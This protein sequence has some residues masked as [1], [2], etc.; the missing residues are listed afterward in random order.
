MRK[1]KILFIAT[2]WT[3]ASK[4][5]KD[6]LKPGYGVEELLSLYPETKELAEIDVYQL[7]NLDSTNVQPSDWTAIA[8]TIE[9]NYK[10]YDAFIIGHG[11]DTM[12][13]T[14][15]ALS[16]ALQDLEKPVILTGSVLAPEEPNSDAKQNLIDSILLSISE[17]YKGV[18]VCFHGQVILGTHSRK[19]KNEATKI[20]RYKEVFSSINVPVI[21]VVKWRNVIKNENYSPKLPFKKNNFH[22]LP[23]FSPEIGFV[24][25]F[26][27]MGWDVLDLYKW[28][29]AIVVKWYW[30]GNL[31]FSY[32]DWEKKIKEFTNKGIG[33][34]IST[35]NPFWEVD[36]DKYEVGQ[37][38]AK[39]GAISTHNMT[40][41]T[42]VVKLMWIFGNYPNYSFD[43]VKQLFLSNIAWEINI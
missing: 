19:M 7:C 9:K 20:D 18:F 11:T 32:G 10:D 14:S 39:W 42:A 26:P 5:T 37:K 24:N 38:A 17:G 23:F 8:Q 12:H 4:K 21:A 34:Y 1:K 43:K 29:K 41:G 40:S 22:I 6:G 36:L 2:G 27:W 31:P 30:P 16:F 13:F 15:S 33:I 3:L 28:K 35:Q 25:L